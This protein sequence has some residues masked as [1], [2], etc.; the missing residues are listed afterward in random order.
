MN[1]KLTLGAAFLAAAILPA[2]AGLLQRADVPADPVWALHIDCDGL[3]PTVIGQYLLTELDKPE[4]QQKF[5][6]FQA[7]FSFDPR[8]QLHGLTLYSVGG[9]PEDA[10]L[11]MYAD[12]DPDRLV[13][14]A[15]AAQDYQTATH[16]QH[17]IHNWIDDR[18]PTRDGVTPRV[19]AAIFGKS[20]VIFGQKEVAVGQALDVLDRTVPSLAKSNAFPQLGLLSD[21][22]IIQGA[23][24]KVELPASDPNAAI[25]RLSKLVHLQVN[26]ANRQLNATLILATADDT[27]AGHLTTIAQGLVALT[28]LQTGK[29]EAVKLANAITVKQEGPGVVLR[30]ALPADDKRPQRPDKKYPGR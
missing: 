15:K 20:I 27:A 25:F 2:R 14:L 16:N 6:T 26:E 13:A 12:F 17:V 11:L 18:R 22:S 24:R 10:V 8:K 23:A 1:A 30:L 28:K 5:A 19:Y 7:L 3:R 4:V 9:S 21:T 29:P